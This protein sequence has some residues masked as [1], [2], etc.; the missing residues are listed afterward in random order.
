[1]TLDDDIWDRKQK[2]IL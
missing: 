2:L 1:M